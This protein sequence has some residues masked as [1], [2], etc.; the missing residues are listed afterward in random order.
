ME[1]EFLGMKME[2]NL[3]NVNISMKNKLKNGIIG[4]KMKI[5]KSE[6]PV[7]I[8]GKQIGK[9]KMDLLL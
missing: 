9:W 3:K 4:M 6:E 7:F 1:N 5:F 8:N 2:L